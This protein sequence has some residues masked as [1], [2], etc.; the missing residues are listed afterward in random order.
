MMHVSI[1]I[2]IVH[3]LVSCMFKH[4]PAY[5]PLIRQTVITTKYDLHVR[6]ALNT[7]VIANKRENKFI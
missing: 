4:H 1:L 3:S 5:I 2:L 6:S 7:E